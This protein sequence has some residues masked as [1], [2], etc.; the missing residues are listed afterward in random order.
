MTIRV[1][2]PTDADAVADIYTPIVAR[3]SI[4]FELTPPS[5]DDIRA[6]NDCKLCQQL[7]R[8]STR[9][10]HMLWQRQGRSCA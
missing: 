9:R 2:S 4:A 5:V 10:R 3:T 8:R 6:W 1:A 7:L